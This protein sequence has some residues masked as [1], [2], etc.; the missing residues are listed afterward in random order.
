MP[1]RVRSLPLAVRLAAW[2]A[3][4]CRLL[5]PSSIDQEKTLQERGLPTEETRDWLST[6]ESAQRRG[7]RA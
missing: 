7:G 5:A 4:W 2:D 3:V 6:E 1:A